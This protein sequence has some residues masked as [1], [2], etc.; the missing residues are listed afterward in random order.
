[1]DD[2]SPAQFSYSVTGAEGSYQLSGTVNFYPA[3]TTVTT[4]GA[5]QVVIAAE[6]PPIIPDP[7][8]IGFAPDGALSG[9]WLLTFISVLNQSYLIE[10][11]GTP[12]AAGWA[13]QGQVNGTADQTTASVPAP[14]PVLFY[15][16]RTP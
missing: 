15:R 11:N 1:V 7:D 14:A 12:A 4:V 5:T 16:V 9:N 13:Q 3:G 2:S 6:P 8:I 10:T